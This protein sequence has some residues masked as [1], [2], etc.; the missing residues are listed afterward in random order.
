MITSAKVHPN[1]YFDMT[2]A[3]YSETDIPSWVKRPT[4]EQ[5]AARATK[6]TESTEAEQP[7][8]PLAPK[9]TL[10]MVNGSQVNAPGSVDSIGS[11]DSVA[12][13][14]VP[15]SLTEEQV[16]LLGQANISFFSN[17]AC[18]LHFGHIDGGPSL[19]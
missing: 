18:V 7:P 17:S 3:G 2:E 10:S 5:V 4:P 11:V 9:E 1:V 19:V 15:A 12:S 8:P 16:R 6:S 13:V 14:G